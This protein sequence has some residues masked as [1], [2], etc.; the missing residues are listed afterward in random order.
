MY[1]LLTQE[2]REFLSI[3]E[4]YRTYDSEEKLLP[5]TPTEIKE[6]WCLFRIKGVLEDCDGYI[7]SDMYK[8]KKL[9]CQLK[10]ISGEDY[11]IFYKSLNC[12]KIENMFNE[13]IEK[14]IKERFPKR[15][16]S[17]TNII[18]TI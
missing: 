15:M 5:S 1:K 14:F 16:H 10:N 18:S 2:E 4:P 13:S 8:V 12:E 3:I 9:Y 17:T 6:I 11:D 7:P